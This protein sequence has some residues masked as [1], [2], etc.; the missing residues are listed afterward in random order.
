MIHRLTVF[1]LLFLGT[2]QTGPVAAEQ[3]SVLARPGPWP[4]ADQLIAYGN[5]IWFSS[6]VK[7]V[8][9][10]SADV[11]SF[12]PSNKAL[13]FE[14][15][16]FS[17]D[18]G[19]PVV[20]KDLLYWPHEDM[21]IGLGTG[22]VNVTNGSS[23][24]TLM[25]P[26]PDYMMH[27][28]S[29]TEWRGQLV[30][31]MAGWNGALVS[32]V[33]GGKNW[34]ILANDKPRTGR[35]HRYNHLA[36]LDGHLYVRH[37]E[38][39]GVSLAEYVDGR[40]MDVEGWPKGASFSKLVRFN[41][42]LYSLVNNPD[43]GRDLW[44]IDQGV[45]E[46]L[47][48]SGPTA[49]RVELVS[50]GARLWLITRDADGGE[51][52]ASPDG[53]KY[54]MESRFDGGIPYSATALTTGS[55]YVGGA[56]DDGRAIL[57]GPKSAP[58]LNR[59]TPQMALPFNKHRRSEDFAFDARREQLVMALGNPETFDKRGR[60]LKE[61]ISEI[62][63]EGPPAN[64]F[65]S[66]LESFVPEQNVSTFGGKFQVPMREIANWQLL[67]AMA[68]NAEPFVPLQMLEKPWRRQPNGP[69][70]WFDEVLMALHAVQRV[71]QN[72]Q[73]TI[74]AL[75]HRLDQQ[76]DPDWLQSQ[77]TGTL[78][79]ITGKRFAYDKAAWKTWWLST[80]RNWPA[81]PAGG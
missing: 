36:A 2:I 28:H 6:A 80:K 30:A 46:K 47:Q 24:Q 41:G 1:C 37:W 57:W 69:Q 44:R 17:Q 66:L 50:D 25:I 16:L 40:V 34:Q 45:V 23:W 27:T 55:I 53:V 60:A 71:G 10:N 14:R 8:N 68:E 42:A 26:S 74:A 56:G 13:Q 49:T 35:F 72:D 61:L 58:D 70:K 67:N 38:T 73:A 22:V 15:Y 32:S 54:E 18:T 75:I 64:F 77:I 9:H 19:E 39:T 7:G 5:K 62:L 21:R 12:D 11:W 52:W 76:G 48:I 65:I 79:A 29:L 4:V 3:L 63:R 51:L 78:G 31:A 20:H 59:S 33:D 43:G 81:A